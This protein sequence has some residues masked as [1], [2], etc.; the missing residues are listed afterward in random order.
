[1]AA[2]KGIMECLEH[3]LLHRGITTKPDSVLVFD[4]TLV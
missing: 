2:Y 4:H 1:M 3:L